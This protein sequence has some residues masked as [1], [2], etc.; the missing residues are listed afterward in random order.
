MTSYSLETYSFLQHYWWLL[1]SLLGALLV[2]LLFVQGGQTFL[3]GTK[4]DKVLNQMLVNSTGRKWEFTLTTLVTFGGAFF[5]SFPLFYSTSFGGAY[6]VWIITCLMFVIQAI[7]Y[8]YQ[9][10]HG[11]VLGKKGYQTLLVING[12]MAPL[13]L[14]AIV[15]TLFMGGNFTVDKSQIYD[16]GAMRGAISEWSTYKGVM[17]H[18]L[19]AVL[20]PWNLVLGVAVLFLARVTGLLY[21]INNID[22]SVLQAKARKSLPLN[23]IIFVVL[24]VA[25]VVKLITMTGL[26]YSPSALDPGVGS[27]VQESFL[28]W[29]NL[30][31]MPIVL[32]IFLVGVLLVLLGIGLT[33]FK[34]NFRKG[35]WIEGVGVVLAVL[36]MLLLAGWNNTAYYPSLADAQSSLSIK[37]SSSSFYT[38]RAMSYV[39]ILIPFVLA[40]IWF[41]WKSIDSKKITRKEIESSEH[42]Y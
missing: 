13:L 28:Y 39:S 21:F 8:E 36:A 24:F 10:K 23:A 40:Y 3:I 15:S 30:L 11:N 4:K 32:I 19:E 6:W 18:G 17:L 34:K 22:D 33:L 26:R 29:H 35:V 12:I 37:N 38:L 42:T 14:G 20:N 1:V 7:S 2:F 9:S 25:Y 31:Q 5:A 27:F 41:A 16:F